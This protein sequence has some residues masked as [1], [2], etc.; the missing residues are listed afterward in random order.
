MGITVHYLDD[1]QFESFVIS[2]VPLSERHTGENICSEFMRIFGDWDIIDKIQA[3]VTD[4][5]ANMVK[6]CQLYFQQN[7]QA[8][9]H[10]PC[11]AHT[12][13]LI[14]YENGLKKNTDLDAL[15]TQMKGIVT[16]FRHSVVASDLLRKKNG[17]ETNP[18]CA[19]TLEFHIRHDR[20]LPLCVEAHQRDSV[21]TAHCSGSSNDRSRPDGRT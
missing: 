15:L 19:H 10:L 8:N 4:S 12:L 21:R 13:H 11:F 5:A 14:V 16:F 7:S 6:T 3:I 9:K 1:F 17:F 18:K 2:T 20:A